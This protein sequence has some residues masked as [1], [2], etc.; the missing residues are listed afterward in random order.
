MKVPSDGNLEL[1]E[2]LSFKAG[3]G[4]IIALHVSHVA[5]N[6]DFRISSL[7]IHSVLPFLTTPLQT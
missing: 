6:F 4:Q 7:L 5:G 1:S 3:E 2:F